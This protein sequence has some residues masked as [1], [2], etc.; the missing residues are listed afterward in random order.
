MER[1]ISSAPRAI[2]GLLRD[3]T[4]ATAILFGFMAVGLM[5]TA[6]LTVDVGQVF[7]A[8]RNFAAATE[9]AALAGAYALSQNN[10]TQA[11]VQAAITAWN[12][13]HPPSKVTITNTSVAVSC[14]TAT[15]NLP[16]CNGTSPNVA[17]VTQTATVSTHFMN[18]FGIPSI[19][20]TSTASASKAGGTSIPLNVMFV[21]DATGSMNSADTG[22]TVPGIAHPTRFQCADYSMQS[23]LKIMPTSMDKVGLMIFPGMAT[24]YSPTSHPCPTQPNST[25]Y[26][27]A[28]IKYQIGTALDATYNNGAGALVNTSPFIQAIG[29]GTSLTGCVTA[30]GGEG[31]YGAEVLAKAQA[32]LP[33]VA[34]TKNVI[35][36]LS[37]G[38]FNASSSQLS[39]QTTKTTK[40]CDQAITAAQA[41]TNAGTTV[42]AVAYG[43]PTSGCSSGDTHNPC[44]TMQAIA[45]DSTKFYSTD[46]SCRITGSANTIGSLPSQFQGIATSLTKPRLV[47][48]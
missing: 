2:R 37:D 43:A 39:N 25:P 46:S 11:T 6:G 42:Y 36:F 26:L 34:G 4:G 21:L 5:G 28:N 40:Q 32:A 48:R 30:K 20:L 17:Q 33:D 15:S 8:K 3:R 1:S 31:S 45:S 41:A 19:T 10:A 18:A 12:T 13:A 27:A 23:I 35:I 47:V 44:T 24:Q 38:D 29:N 22:C 14:D 16:T 9:A 7:V